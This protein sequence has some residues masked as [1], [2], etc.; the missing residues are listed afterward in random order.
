MEN[1]SLKIKDDVIKWIKTWYAQNAPL[2][3][4][5]IVIGISGGAISNILL[6]TLCSALGPENIIG[7]LMRDST[8]IKADT[9][10]L[11]ICEYTKVKHVRLAIFPAINALKNVMTLDGKVRISEKTVNNLPARMRMVM[12]YAYSQSVD[13]FVVSS[14]T[15][16]DSFIGHNTIYGDGCGD[17]APF[18]NLTR[19]EIMQIGL[20][21]GMNEQYINIE[22]DDMLPASLPDEEKFKFTYKELDSYIRT[23]LI[24][25]TRSKALIDRAHAMTKYKRFKTESFNPGLYVY[26]P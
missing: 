18:A 17:F 26:E 10:G 11:N 8:D 14:Q 23:G 25:N 24:D 5:P 1:N 12:L 9:P 16:S 3:N 13:G 6:C 22:P 19:E 7:V 21:L 15:L 20:E 2:T 4:T